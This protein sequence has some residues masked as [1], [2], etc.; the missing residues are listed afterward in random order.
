MAIWVGFSVSQ[1]SQ[2]QDNLTGAG[3]DPTLRRVRSIIVLA[4]AV[5]K[6]P[7]SRSIQRSLLDLPLA[8]GATIADRH[9]AAASKFAERAGLTSLD[10]RII[11][12]SDSAIPKDHEVCGVVRS[13]VERDASPIRG[14]AGVLADATRDHD[15]DDYVVVLNGAQVFR[16]PMDDL[17]VR[18]LRTQSDVSMVSAR[19]GTPVGLWLMRCEP[20]LSVRS[21]GYV[22]LKEQALEEWR[23]RWAIHVIERQRA[24][25]LRTRSVNEYLNAIRY[26]ATC[27]LG[28]DSVDEDPYR[29]EWACSF[30]MVETTGAVADDAVIHDSVVLDGAKVGAGAVVVRSVICPGATVSPGS[31]VAGRVLAAGEVA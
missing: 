10:L 8:D 27:P 11:V 17:I 22:D 29:E 21:V 24:P 19:D 30:A 2:K 20:L 13:V 1:V 15:P 3:A 5:T 28:G 23:E 25:A 9:V 31:R 26:A 4:G 6:T 7:L 16:D 14:V 18:M 12:D